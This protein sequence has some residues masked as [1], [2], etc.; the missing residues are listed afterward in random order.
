VTKKEREEEEESNDA[1]SLLE[2]DLAIVRERDRKLLLR[3]NVG[4]CEA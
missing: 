1:L 4:L 2:R 3:T